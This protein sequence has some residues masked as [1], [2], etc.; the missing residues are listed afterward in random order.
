MIVT[1]ELRFVEREIKIEHEHTNGGIAIER[2]TIRVLQQRWA[3]PYVSRADAFG[4]VD[5]SLGEPTEW[6]DVPCVKED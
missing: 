1:N 6:R 5:H 2:K 3:T 4:Q